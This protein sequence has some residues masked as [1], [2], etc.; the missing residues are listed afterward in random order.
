MSRDSSFYS[1]D[2]ARFV[3]STTIPL[4]K[5]RFS[6]D[7]RSQARSGEVSTWMGDRLGIP[8]VVDFFPFLKKT[9]NFFANQT[10]QNLKRMSKE[11]FSEVQ[12]SA[13]E[14]Y[15]MRKTSK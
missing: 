12:S 9:E 6:S 2:F 15:S 5:Y 14:N 1:Y 3:S 11:G 4:G 13:F 8:R 10:K 7:H